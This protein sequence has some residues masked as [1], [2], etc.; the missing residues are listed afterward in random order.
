M[1]AIESTP[2]GAFRK[3]A[4]QI[5]IICAVITVVTAFIAGACY[6]AAQSSYNDYLNGYSSSSSYLDDD[7]DFS[8]YDALNSYQTNN[9]IASLCVFAAIVAGSV[10]AIGAFAWVGASLLVANKQTHISDAA[11]IDRS[12]ELAAVD[13]PAY[14]P[15][16]SAV[17]F[18]SEGDT[19]IATNA[20][21]EKIGLLNAEFTKYVREADKVENVSAFIASYHGDH[22]VVRII[23][24][25]K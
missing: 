10:S 13:D 15:I 1:E 2:L 12:L 7:D 22:P 6:G 16:G 5:T 9:S 25:Q 14:A 23:S 17:S 21:G 11:P 18:Q 24:A 4:K 19:L 8:S 20:S 3:K